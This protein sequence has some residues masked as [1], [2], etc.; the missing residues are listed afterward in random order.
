MHLQVQKSEELFARNISEETAKISETSARGLSYNLTTAL[1]DGLGEADIDAPLAAEIKKTKSVVKLR[2]QFIDL[3]PEVV[4][5]LMENIDYTARGEAGASKSKSKAGG[6]GNT[7]EHAEKMKAIREAQKIATEMAAAIKSGIPMAEAQKMAAAQPNAIKAAQGQKQM[8]A[9]EI[10]QAALKPAL[11][12]EVAQ[13]LTREGISID[14]FF[15]PG[16]NKQ[17]F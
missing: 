11:Q 3:S 1:A 7:T 13:A 2:E 5:K 8:I 6:P 10:P 16:L 9:Q 12:Q 14:V 17:V 4:A 15:Q